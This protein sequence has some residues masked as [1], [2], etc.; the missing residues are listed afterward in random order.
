MEHEENGLYPWDIPHH[1]DGLSRERCN[2]TSLKRSS[3]LNHHRKDVN[4]KCLADC[5]YPNPGNVKKK[6]SIAGV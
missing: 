1:S 6:E 5:M 2:Y 4:R 3:I